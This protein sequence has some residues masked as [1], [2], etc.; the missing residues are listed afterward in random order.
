MNTHL[1]SRRQCLQASALAAW[2]GVTQSTLAQA[3][4]QARHLREMQIHPVP[5]LG[6]RIWVE[7]QPPWEAELNQAS[8]HPSFIVQSPEQHHPPV[9]M[10]YASWPQER[11]SDTQLP[12]VAHTAIQRA[13]QNFGLNLAQAR[14]VVPRAAH[15]GGFRGF[16]GQ[17]V[18]RMQGIAM[19]VKIFVGQHSGRFPVALSIYTLEGKMGHLAEVLRRSWGQLEYLTG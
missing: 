18:G 14:A 7:N 19:D 1:L 12:Q 3:R 5:A 16:E 9:V 15:Y 6:L 8:G 11:V 4:P 2:A 17:C 13:S 10:T